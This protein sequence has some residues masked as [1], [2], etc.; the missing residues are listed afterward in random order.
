VVGLELAIEQG[1]AAD[2]QTRDE[3]GD[4]DLRSIGSPAEHA[5]TEKGAPQLDPVKPADQLAVRV[6]RLD[7]MGMTERVKRQHGSFDLRVD[8]GFLPVG[9][10]QQNVVERLITADPEPSRTQPPGKAP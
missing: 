7:R 4:S 8:P 5:F 6:P 1:E 10:G 2:L 3:P 9:A